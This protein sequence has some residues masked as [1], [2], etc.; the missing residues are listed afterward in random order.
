VS[1][2]NSII[3]ALLF[4]IVIVEIV[5]LAPKDLG[6]SPA[7]DGAN[8]S[9]SSKV[10]ENAASQIMSGVHLVEA[11]HDGKEWELWA[12]KALRPKDNDDWDIEQVRVKF[13]ASNGVIYN[14]TGKKGHVVP[15]KNDMK[16]EGNVITRS[17][18]GY[19]FKTES[20]FYDSKNRLL[21]SPGD[22]EMTGPK[23]KEGG[24]LYLTGAE[25]TA[26][27]ATNLINVNRNVHARKNL[28]G[29]K[30]VTIESQRALFSGKTNSAQFFGNVVIDAETMRITGPEARFVYGQKAQSLDSVEV[31]GGIRVTD[32]DK[33]AT[34][35]SVNVSFKDDRVVFN[36]SPRVVQNGDELVGDQI[37]FLDGGH[38]VQVSN[39]KAEMDPRNMEK[40]K[41]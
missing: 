24:Q 21:T 32:T 22:V 19:V 26:E 38:K 4:F 5:V 2:R 18:N 23:D 33:F 15:S 28:K 12:V 41:Q 17:S 8:G 40:K 1:K 34:S 39:A 7:E 31:V 16:I 11:K 29:D 36:G 37:V 10:G 27:F 13:F 14:V 3:L 9:A 25:M 35:S 30:V 20:A 6:I